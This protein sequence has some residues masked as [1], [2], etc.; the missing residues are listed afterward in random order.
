MANEM[1]PASIPSEF[2]DITYRQV[3][4]SNRIVTE[5]LDFA[6]TRPLLRTSTD[7]HHLV[8]ELRGL[9]PLGRARLTNMVPKDL[10][11]Q[12]LDRDQLRQVLANLVQNAADAAS[13]GRDAG[14]P[15]DGRDGEV[16]VHARVGVTGV[17]TIEVEDDGPGMPSEVASRAFEPLFTTKRKGTGLGLAIVTKNVAAHGGEVRFEDR[18]PNGTRFIV[19]IP[20]ATA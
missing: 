2:F 13:A 19:E 9:V 11:P 12:L 8:E 3:K 10:A 18:A 15:G 6:R 4:A 16:W 14:A 5:L 7:L 20:P 17:L 1:T